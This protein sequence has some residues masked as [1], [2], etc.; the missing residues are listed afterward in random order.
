MHG[1]RTTILILLEL[2]RSQTELTEVACCCRNVDNNHHH[3][4]SSLQNEVN[5]Q[6]NLTYYID[7]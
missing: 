2:L 5:F 6:F 1:N 7:N 3:T 4:V